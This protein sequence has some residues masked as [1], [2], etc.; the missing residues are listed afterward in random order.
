M[1]RILLLLTAVALLLGAVGQAQA[2]PLNPGAFPSQGA[3]DLTSSISIS[4]DGSPPSFT[5][6]GTT[7][8]GVLFNEGTA[9]NP[10]MLAIP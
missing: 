3:L 6:G 8:N 4:T 2:G 1:K 10:N 5:F 7:Y 9:A